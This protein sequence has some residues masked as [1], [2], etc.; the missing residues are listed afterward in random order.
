M[1][2]LNIHFLFYSLEEGVDPPPFACILV[3]MW[4]TWINTPAYL[5]LLTL[6]SRGGGINYLVDK[7]GRRS[8]GGHDFYWYLPACWVLHPVSFIWLGSVGVLVLVGPQCWLWM[9]KCLTNSGVG[10]WHDYATFSN[11]TIMDSKSSFNVVDRFLKRRYN[12]A[13]LPLANW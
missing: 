12:K 7:L 8:G 2:H 10:N 11:S 3:P 4:G 9:V 6:F 1:K 13:I 5:S